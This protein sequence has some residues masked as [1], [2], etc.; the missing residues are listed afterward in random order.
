MK[1]NNGKITAL[2]ALTSMML[3]SSFVGVSM[4]NNVE[5][6]AVKE[7]S[8]I[9]TTS[10]VSLNGAV[11]EH[12]SWSVTP[13]VNGSQ[14]TAKTLQGLYIDSATSYSGEFAGTF[15]GST[16]LEYKFPGTTQLYPK[17][18]DAMGN[19]YFRITSVANPDYWVQA[20]IGPRYDKTNGY[21]VA[22]NANIYFTG[23]TWGDNARWSNTAN[24]Q[25]KTLEYAQTTGSYGAPVF[26]SDS[27]DLNNKLY[28]DVDDNG[29]MSI[30]YNA[31]VQNTGGKISQAE[32]KA[33]HVVL[34]GATNDVRDDKMDLSKGYKISFGSNLDTT[35]K[36]N[37][38]AGSTLTELTPPDA[39]TPVCFFALNDAQLNT[40][41]VEMEL[42]EKKL[43]AEGS[44]SDNGRNY[45]NLELGEQVKDIALGYSET[46]SFA[47]TFEYLSKE[48]ADILIDSSDIDWN[49][50]QVGDAG[51]LVAKYNGLEEIFYIK[52][53]E[54]VQANDYG[55]VLLDDLSEGVKAQP[56]TVNKGADAAYGYS[57]LLVSSPQAYEGAFS[58]VFY[59]STSIRYKFPGKSQ[60]KFYT[61]PKDVNDSSIP[62]VE[63]S[64]SQRGDGL[65]DFYFVVHSVADPSQSFEIHIAP[66]Y[67]KTGLN[68]A[69]TAIYVKAKD[70]SGTVR[71]Y[72]KSL[73]N[74]KSANWTTSV[75][76]AMVYSRS[77]LFN[78][79]LNGASG[80]FADNLYFD[81]DQNGI[82]SV[83]YDQRNTT[84]Y[85]SFPVAD[86]YGKYG[87]N[88]NYDSPLVRFDSSPLGF[89]NP[90][91]VDGPSSYGAVFDASK[92]YTI[93]F[94]SN[95]DMNG[96]YLKPDWDYEKGTSAWSE[97]EDLS[98]YGVDGGTDVC[99]LSVGGVNLTKQDLFLTSN[100]DIEYNGDFKGEMENEELVYTMQGLEHLP[101]SH[102][103]TT[104]YGFSNNWC[105]NKNQT[106]T[107]FTVENMTGANID[108]P[109]RYPTI[110]KISPLLENVRPFNYHFYLEV[111][112]Q[113]V[114][115]L[116]TNGGYIHGDDLLI[117]YAESMIPELPNAVW[118]DMDFLGWY[119]EP[120]FSTKITSITVDLGTRTL[121]AK[122]LDALAPIITLNGKASF[123]TY[124][125]GT[126]N[127]VQA[128]DVL[129]RDNA[130]GDISSS[131]IVITVKEPNAT[132]FVALS[133]VQFNQ[134]GQ[135]VVKYTVKDSYGNESSLERIIKL[136]PY[137]APEI[138]VQGELVAT[139]YTNKKVAVPV[140]TCTDGTSVEV[141]VFLNGNS[142]DIVNGSFLPDVAGRYTVC[143]YAKNTDGVEN[144]IE[145]SV[146]V[147]DDEE[148]P[149]IT[150]ELEELEV[151]VGSTV[152]I[153]EVTVLD[154]ADGE[155]T[156]TIKV[157]LGLQEVAFSNGEFVAGQLGAY[158][159]TYI[160]QDAMGLK[161]EKQVVIY[162]R[163][164]IMDENGEV[165]QVPDKFDGNS[166]LVF[167]GNVTLG[168]LLA[169]IVVV[170]VIIVFIAAIIVFKKKKLK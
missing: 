22:N 84:Q 50:V 114:I 54:T 16:T 5:A 115:T 149:V 118:Q 2:V 75:T 30:G 32:T 163:E 58:G 27:I 109:G 155:L 17:T 64:V 117:E 48:P 39:G 11:A 71:Y 88:E 122:W 111:Q 125:V 47:N 95:F 4:L 45:L 86:N 61:P 23:S 97:I 140:A 43:Y 91:T 80:D 37:W 167:G 79:D 13:Y 89:V 153:P 21:Y 63:S 127:L 102:T 120:Q 105:F 41:S 169:I 131:K 147:Q 112:K 165:T 151:L 29:V 99:F 128:T 15:N 82:M 166:N 19:F 85:W 72:C 87:Q 113:Y 92:G 103:V 141:K 146:L 123:E 116:E 34:N 62:L 106:E 38:V 94:G 154:N 78:S 77:A 69:Q 46:Y 36:Y 20:N 126:Q 59:D 100:T 12:K 150:L 156:P 104:R 73:G 33:T 55:N 152:R 28:I 25:N 81:I 138:S 142:Y 8:A 24:G 132:S 56:I 134:S 6:E 110:A 31:F 83:Y 148:A 135:Y 66:Y 49:S 53:G 137:A 121:Y 14:S 7:T 164:T 90:K 10:I 101:A 65:G 160:A 124:V 76:N 159:I 170:V 139:S 44:Y 18:G 143:Y 52:F 74:D 67:T 107:I 158:T 108:V 119:L 161:T 35:A 96:T 26:N 60:M 144:A 40:A 129:A 51:R 68:A 70:T 9:N 162:A 130:D 145:Y 1:R 42:K 168:V 133:N 93:S 57:G 3:L 136:S 157:T 98:A